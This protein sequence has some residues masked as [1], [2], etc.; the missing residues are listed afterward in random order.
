[1][2]S[3]QKPCGH[4][5]MHMRHVFQPALRFSHGEGQLLLRSA[6]GACARMIDQNATKR[7]RQTLRPAVS[8]LALSCRASPSAAAPC[9]AAPCRAARCVALPDEGKGAPSKEGT[10][11]RRSR[12][13]PHS[14]R[15]RSGVCQAWPKTRELTQARAWGMGVAPVRGGTFGT[16]QSAV[17]HWTTTRMS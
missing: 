9:L 2:D 13:S 3:R 4:A 12:W 17:D 6:S 16:G 5:G 8:C 7:K 15:V 1:M 11:R 14:M 10:G